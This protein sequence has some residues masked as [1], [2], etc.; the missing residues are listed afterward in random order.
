MAPLPP[1]VVVT[2]AAA[3]L[4]GGGGG[5]GGGTAIQLEDV[6]HFVARCKVDGEAT[7]AGPRPPP[8]PS[9]YYLGGLFAPVTPTVR[10]EGLGAWS[11]PLAFNATHAAAA[12]QRY[13]NKELAPDADLPTHASQPFYLGYAGFSLRLGVGLLGAAPPPGLV[14]ALEC[15]LNFSGSAAHPHDADTPPATIHA[16]L[17]NNRMGSVANAVNPYRQGRWPG[18]STFLSF[19]GLMLSRDAKTGAPLA[20]TLAAWNQLQY[21][22]LAD[23]VAEAHG[24]AAV[25][26]LFP[27]GD[28]A[29][30]GDDLNCAAAT[31]AA[32][33]K[34]GL[35][36]VTNSFN[37]QNSLAKSSQRGATEFLTLGAPSLFRKDTSGGSG[38][39][40]DY[41]MCNTPGSACTLHDY[42][43]VNATDADLINDTDIDNFM[44]GQVAG[45]TAGAIAGAKP[46][47]VL[48]GE[49][50]EPGW[51]WPVASPPVATSTRVRGRWQSFLAS[52]GLGPSDLGASSWAGV[53]PLGRTGAGAGEPGASP[54]ALRRLYYWS[55]RF[56]VH[57]AISYMRNSTARLKLAMN[58]PAAQ[59]YTN[60]VS[61]LVVELFSNP[62]TLKPFPFALQ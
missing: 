49:Q 17:S 27:I 22:D 6:P 13:P 54:L 62:K 37:G 36:V 15:Q 26:K 16:R 44:Q 43:S 38:G 50:D 51:F 46:H 56:S 31:T 34:L 14:L 11:A 19:P 7:A 28:G 61:D 60:F 59:I 25:P 18:D 1:A 40:G 8:A 41:L 55:M 12:A 52:Q 3:L 39:G 24:A 48:T 32:M 21:W 10:A 29:D 42:C 58:D 57:D 5:G 35:S 47:F 9:S 4:F 2:V 30:N 45:F 20:M 53:V 33:A 23:S